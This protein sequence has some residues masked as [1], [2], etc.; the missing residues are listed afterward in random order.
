MGQNF[1]IVC[2]ISILPLECNAWCAMLCT[3]AILKILCALSYSTV[4]L[5]TQKQPGYKKRCGPV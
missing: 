2:D 5:S 1:S 4:V 3:A